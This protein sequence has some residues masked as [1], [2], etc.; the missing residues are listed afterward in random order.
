MITSTIKLR[1]TKK[2]ED[3]LNAWLWNLTGIYNWALRK[4]ELNAQDKIYFTAFD[5]VNLL[6][7]HGKKLDIPCASCSSMIAVRNLRGFI[8]SRG[9]WMFVLTPQPL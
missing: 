7:D 6:A 2:Q 9:S 4:I 3:T 5:F 8:P 1:L